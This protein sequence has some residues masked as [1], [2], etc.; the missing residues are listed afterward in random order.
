MRAEIEEQATVLVDRCW[1]Y[2][3]TLR[4]LKGRSFDMALLV[5]R[6]SSDHAA[7]YL[8]Y[9]LEIHLQLPV[10][11]AAPSVLTRYGSRVRYPSCIAVGIS[12]SGAAPDVSEVLGEMRAQ[13]HTTLAITNHPVSRVGEA[14]EFVL[15][16]GV[17]PELAVAATKTYTASLLACYQV[18]RALG[19]DLLMPCDLLPDVA[20]IERCRESAQA[21]LGPVL[22]FPTLFAL[23]RGYGFATAQET[24]LKLMECALLPC[25][26]YST[27]DF[28]HG[29]KAL[30]SYGTAA[31]VYGES[32]VS[33]E[34]SQCAVVRAEPGPGGPLGPIWEIVFGQWL[35]LLAAQARGL[36]PDQPR[37]LSKVTETL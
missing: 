26:S 34:R 30:L 8:R 23:A 15:D 25:K 21:S 3:E 19:G 14:A 7:L 32:P 20:W 18:V 2:E 29:P 16:L 6:G 24:A 17:G 37:N 36:D 11:L 10:S 28:E 33:L 1:A 13:G 5:A 9:L 22:R 27:A 4:P 12:Q 35:A 31:I